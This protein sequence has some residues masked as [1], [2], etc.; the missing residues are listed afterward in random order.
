MPNVPIFKY[1]CVHKDETETKKWKC[2]WWKDYKLLE[3]PFIIL[4]IDLIVKNIVRQSK[5][6]NIC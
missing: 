2:L 6:D 5:G 3:F 1:L 4:E